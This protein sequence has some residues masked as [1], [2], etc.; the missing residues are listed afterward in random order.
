MTEDP[1]LD[2]VYPV[3]E[4]TEAGAF[5]PRLVYRLRVFHPFENLALAS[6]LAEPK[7]DLVHLINVSCS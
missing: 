6:A 4:N 7:A 5:L 1:F 3:E 2:V